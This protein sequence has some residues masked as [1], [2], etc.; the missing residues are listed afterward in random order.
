MRVRY[1]MCGELYRA[2]CDLT[3][4]QA[5][6]RFDELKN[7][8]YC[9]WAELVVED[10]YDDDDMY[11]EIIDEFDNNDARDLYKADMEM[12]KIV[13]ELFK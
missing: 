13:A 9:E 12:K 2:D 1:Q 11:M 6:K 4:K 5:R 3:P 7:E 8:R 10:D